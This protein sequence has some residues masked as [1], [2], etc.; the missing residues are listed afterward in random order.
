[1]KNIKF[2]SL[3]L[4]AALSTN[5]LAQKTYTFDDGVALETDWTVAK[6]V[7]SGGEGLCEIS[8]NPGGGSWSPKNGN[9][10]L[11]SFKNKSEITISITSTASFSN[12]SNI[13]YDAVAND[14]SKPNF[15]LDI[16][17]DNGAVVK[18]I[19]SHYG[20]KDKFG[21]GGTN[22]WGV[23]NSDISP[24]VS[25]HIKITLYAS[26]SGKYAAIDNIQITGS[27]GPVAVTGVALN[28]ET[29]TIEAGQT[30][31][32][33]AIVAPDNAENKNISWSSSNS[34]VATVDQNGV[35]SALSAGT[36]NITVTTEDGEFTA[37]C[38]V[39]VTAPAEPIPVTAIS[40]SDVT[41]AVGGTTTLTVNYTPADANTG[42][43]ITSWTSS[44]T[45]V[46]TVTDGT[47]KGLAAGTSKITATTEGG[48]TASCTVTV[49]VVKV[50]GVSLN[51]NTL[52]LQI[53]GTETLTATVSPSDATDKAITWSSDSPAV[54][55]VDENGSVFAISEGT[56]TITVTTADGGFTASC[57]VTVTA[58][59]PVPHTDL[60]LHVQGIYDGRMSEGGYGDKLSTFDNREYEVYFLGRSGSSD[61]GLFTKNGNLIST[62]NTGTS[63]RADWLSAESK[64]ETDGTARTM[65]EEFAGANGKGN[66]KMRSGDKLLLHI[67]GY[68]QFTLWA[69]DNN[70]DVSK[71]KYLRVYVNDVEQSPRNLNSSDGGSLRRF[72][73]TTG[74]QV[75]KVTVNGD[76]TCKPY[77][78]SLR[79]AQ[80]PRLSWKKGNDSTQTVL[81]TTSP[82]PVYYFTKY[83]SKGETR[84]IWEGAKADGIT[85]TTFGSGNDGDTLVLGGTA[86]CPVGTYRYRVAAYYHGVETNSF[87]GT[88][89]VISQLKAISDTIV[90]GYLN[91]EIDPIQFKYY[92]L[93]AD[94]IQ[95]R[96][97]GTAPTGITASEQ[98]GTFTISGTPTV[99]GTFAYSISLPGADS[100]SGKII[101][102]EIDLGNNPILY[103]Y[104]NNQAYTK[105]GIYT[106]LTGRGKNLIPRKAKIEGKRPVEQYK[107]YKW[108][109]ISEDAD[110]NNEEVLAVM[111]G[112]ADVP[113]L[114]M[115][116]FTYLYEVDDPADPM[117]Y[118]GEP[119]NGSL[120]DNG[121][122]ITVQR[123]D[124]PIFR[125]LN[126][127]K[128]DRIQ[129]LD[130]IE[131]KGLMP[132][133][134]RKQ[135]TLCLA[136][137]LTRDIN[138]YYGDGEMQTVLHEIPTGMSGT[139]KKYI[140]LPI[141]SN[142]SN[143][144]TVE[145]KKLLEEVITYLTGDASSVDRPALQIMSFTIDGVVG[146][147]THSPSGNTIEMEIDL[148]A[149]PSLDITSVVP[150]I[151]TA[152]DYTHYTPG[153]E[154]GV[155][156][157][158]SMFIPVQYI[159]TDYINRIVYNVTV[160]S[161]RSEG[162]EQV[163]SIGDWV[164]IYD[165]YGRKIA[166]TNEN[167]YSIELPHGIYVVV[168]ESGETVKITR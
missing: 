156:F 49:N 121:C 61:C 44:N 7:P 19:Y 70:T 164:N 102:T 63:L 115:N 56:A 55:D 98:D 9:F 110:A 157:S 109:L 152:S 163:Y 36:A 142:S 162:I 132:I 117:T 148:S 78:F 51:K 150:Q 20:S 113:V 1:M 112:E 119:N 72:D 22:K 24:A 135:G 101:I 38:V 50:T 123:D 92:A 6:D 76:G 73:I 65:G 154:Q 129:V 59:A 90:D 48:K 79:V 144:L 42:K 46:A 45:N 41:L 127:K 5:V 64:D 165:I 104:K 60:A 11:F 26:S 23:S 53:G 133:N 158:T 125:A 105:D 29:T 93:S 97:L 52:G 8:Q 28:K 116:A 13:K 128:G 25:G 32:L 81:Q 100:Y 83:N 118:W 54:A 58:G 138:D 107:L 33:V 21:T 82:R 151:T 120:S 155:D 84:L 159:L 124:H 99:T 167:I 114:N 141:A 4:F 168:T 37:T 122:F 130:T 40:L 75:I 137:S 77:G 95:F 111:R 2:I 67:K 131:R 69:K 87:T 146:D 153:P 15:T 31:T 149:H 62:T 126:K 47:V 10:L 35:V 86:L 134:I 140:S 16:V 12:I 18:N 160:R 57:T 147:I 71:D 14:N 139:T 91:E 106:Y 39:T 103:L 68:D 3:V 136:T 66:I 34:S 80:E 96:W 89:N 30:E 108:I 88:L 161:Y 17:D 145:G 94:D 74:E 43:A 143:R 27:A 85:L 166:T